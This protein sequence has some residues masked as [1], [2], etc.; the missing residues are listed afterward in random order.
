MQHLDSPNRTGDIAE[1]Y[2]VTW[3]WDNGYEVFKNCGCTGPID[4]IAKDDKGNLLL[5]DVKTLSIDNRT[6]SYVIKNN[7]T[8]KQI[9]L[10]VQLVGFNPETRKLHF[11]KHRK[12]K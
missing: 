2:A 11:V 6:C 10:G 9:K 4:I 12:V 3:L 8:K 5:L 1:H 7:R